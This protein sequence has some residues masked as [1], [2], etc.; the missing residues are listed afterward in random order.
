MLTYVTGL[1]TYL[2]LLQTY[3]LTYLLTFITDLLTYLPLLQTYLLTYL[4]TYLPLLQTYLLTYLCYRPTYLPTYVTS[5]PTYLPML[6]AYLLTYLRILQGSATLSM[7]YAGN[8]FVYSILQALAGESGIV[9]CAFVHSDIAE[10]KY[11][12]TPI[13][14]G[15]SIYATTYI[16]YTPILL[17][18][19]IYTW[20]LCY[21][22]FTLSLE[23]FV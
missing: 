21:I 3:L 9:E 11:F 8:K 14:L 5:L 23:G 19:R 16:N 6:Q 18:V 22:Y 1:L 4:L 10:A 7:A 2:P 15:V 12:S 13:L 20:V 17:G